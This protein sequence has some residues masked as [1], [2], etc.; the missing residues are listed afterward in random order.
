M[1][2]SAL[3]AACA[4]QTRALNEQLADQLLEYTSEPGPGDWELP[5]PDTSTLSKYILRG[6]GRLHAKRRIIK[7]RNHNFAGL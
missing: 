5:I 6:T 1:G 2:H 7:R 4:N 3:R